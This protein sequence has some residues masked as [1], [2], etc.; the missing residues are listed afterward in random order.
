[1]NLSGWLVVPLLFFI[2][3]EVLGY[4]FGGAFGVIALYSLLFTPLFFGQFFLIYVCNF[5]YAEANSWVSEVE[6]MEWGL[7]PMYSIW[8]FENDRRRWALEAT[9]A[10]ALLTI[11]FGTLFLYLMTRGVAS[12]EGSLAGFLVGSVFL[13][14]VALSWYEGFWKPRTREAKFEADEEFTEEKE[15]AEEEYYS[16][17]KFG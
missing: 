5:L 14:L 7:N 2:I 4:L 15:T 8:L 1:M 3:I 9:I 17:Y 16:S 13:A 12:F 6:R 10:T 11:L